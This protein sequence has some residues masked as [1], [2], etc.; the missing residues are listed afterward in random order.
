M[1]SAFHTW[2][3]VGFLCL[4]ALRQTFHSFSINNCSWIEQNMVCKHVFIFINARAP[5]AHSTKG[6]QMTAPSCQSKPYWW[7][8]P[9]SIHSMVPKDE[10][11]VPL[12]LPFP[13]ETHAGTFSAM[14]SLVV[15]PVT[16]QHDPP[17]LC[18]ARQPSPFHS[19]RPMKSRTH[20][21]SLR[22]EYPLSC[23][24][25][26]LISHGNSWTNNFK[27]ISISTQRWWLPNYITHFVM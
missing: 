17:K 20:I 6:K 2:H 15:P 5:G 22:Q 10:T 11:P 9:S 25:Y 19:T 4:Q 23:D 13:T 16:L 18:L 24:C 14:R 1:L 3:G 21:Y 12:Q 27:N 7:Q 26:E 8:T